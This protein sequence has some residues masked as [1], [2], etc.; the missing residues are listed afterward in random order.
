[1]ITSL[2]IRNYALIDELH[3]AFAPGLTI[4]TGE[5]GAG[6]SIILGGLGLIMGQRADTKA[7]FDAARK[8]IV[9][10]H[11]NV[12]AYGLQE[13]FTEHELDYDDELVIRREI[14]PSGKTRTFVNDTPTKLSVLQDL[15]RSLIDLHQQFDTLDIHNVS[16]QLRMLDALASNQTLLRQYG[17]AYAVYQADRRELA[18]LQAEQARLRTEADFVTFQLAEL[19]EADVQAG[20][21]V[22]LESELKTLERAEDIKK[23][24]GETGYKLVED[25]NAVVSQ[26]RDLVPPVDGLRGINE[27]LDKQ[28]Q[29]LE[30]LRY[31]LDDLGQTF[32]DLAEN[33][34]FDPERIEEVNERLSI[35]YKLIKKHG[36]ADDAGLLEVQREYESRSQSTKRVDREIKQLDKSLATQLRV[37]EERA[38]ELRARRKSVVDDFLVK[39]HARL[40][41]LSMAS[42]RLAIEFQELDT[43]GPLGMDQ[44]EYLFSANK[45]SR[46]QPIKGQ[47][48]GGELSRLTLVTKSLVASAIPLPTLIFDEIDSGV[49][50]DV[51]LRMGE[52]LH[53]LS[54]EHQVVTI[55]HSP[56]VASQADRH[57][58]VYKEDLGERTATR[59]RELDQPARVQA[60][61]VMLSSDPPSK[62]ALAN[63][64]G[65]LAS[66]KR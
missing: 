55:T 26:L 51:A 24:L 36:V 39:I 63:A 22:V 13:F 12:G 61:A 41:K 40:A 42:A 62:P 57:Y 5:T 66:A 54:G 21:M 35:I 9:E 2:D 32:A 23:V 31:E 48:S 14:L 4:I 29:R 58:F 18:K 59:V 33:T 27:E 7:L 46:M 47:A 53:E 8:C 37:L 45:G 6:K 64:A 49:S 3:V 60:I 44:V 25:E 30:E 28:I 20:E 34:E 10:A 65:L 56:Q 19:A 15:S 38:F 1:M 52:I 50:G 17:G 11:F 43:P 16:F